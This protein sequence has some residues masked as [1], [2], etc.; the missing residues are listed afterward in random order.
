MRV[1]LGVFMLL[2]AVAALVSVP[3]LAQCGVVSQ[4]IAERDLVAPT[5]AGVLH[6]VK[7]MRLGFAE[8]EDMMTGH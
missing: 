6:Q 3:A 5:L 1:R 7:V 2:G 4:L 8:T